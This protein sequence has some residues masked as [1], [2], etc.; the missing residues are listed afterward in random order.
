MGARLP[1]SEPAARHIRYPV[2]EDVQHT[3]GTKCP[4]WWGD[5]CAFKWT[6]VDCLRLLGL[7]TLKHSSD[8]ERKCCYAVYNCFLSQALGQ[9]QIYKWWRGR[10]V[11]Y[12]W[13]W[14]VLLIMISRMPI[15]PFKPF[16]PSLAGLQAVHR[17]PTTF[18]FYYFAT[19]GY[20]DIRHHGRQECHYPEWHLRSFCDYG[21]LCYVLFLVSRRA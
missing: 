17:F 5:A 3:A 2:G 20:L 11:N 21:T 19:R 10:L 6:R 14:Y 12:D 15:Q 4:R 1:N 9:D 8:L 18:P 13:Y 7:E 16:P